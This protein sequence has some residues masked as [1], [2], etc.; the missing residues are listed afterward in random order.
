MASKPIEVRNVK[1]SEE[2]SSSPALSVQAL[3]TI[4][5]QESQGT[6][7]QTSWTWFLDKYISINFIFRQN[8]AIK[9]K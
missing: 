8:K 5:R 9:Y 6:P 1:T 4:N 7:L 2:L 3:K